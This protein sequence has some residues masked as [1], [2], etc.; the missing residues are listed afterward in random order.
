MD[1]KYKICFF[2]GDI[3]RNGGTERV[4]TQIANGL[5]ERGHEVFFLSYSGGNTSHYF[6]DNNIKL[7]SLGLENASGFFSR[8]LSPYKRL[9]K[10]LK[11][12]ETDIIVDI[13]VLLSLYTL[14][15]KSV[16]GVKVISWEHFN[17]LENKVKTRVLARRL[18]TLFSDCI[19]TLNKS[20]REN[21]LNITPRKN[22]K[23]IRYIYNPAVSHSNIKTNLENKQVIAVG[24]L[25]YQKNFER[26]L[27]LWK[28]TEKRNDDWK[29]IIV[30]EGEGK[31][32]LD[33]LI[34]ENNI[35]NVSILGFRD[36]IETLYERSSIMV[37]TS[38][39]EGLPM[40]L[41]EGQKKGLPIVAFDCPTGPAEI[42]VN[43]KNGYLIDYNND[44]DFINKLD[45]LMN[46][47]RKLK[48]FSDNAINDADRFNLDTIIDKWVELVN[49]LF[50]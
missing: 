44:R 45:G 28:E 39:F 2:S 4:A 29:L 24:R 22:R 23:N 20:D 42:V 49:S 6:L 17:L 47:Q 1:K 10:F 46:N 14:P 41:L 37:M 40:V 15:I 21:Y 18:A 27:K 34:L 12:K 9:T 32:T 7:Y 38:R 5:N 26:L 16:T 19:V 48:E 50:K 31:S 11:E 30:G 13:D 33:N 36:D 25:T 43:D 35:N 3:S 8:K